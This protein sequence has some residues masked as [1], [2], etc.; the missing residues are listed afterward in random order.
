[1]NIEAPHDCADAAFEE[2]AGERQWMR[3]PR[4]S[5]FLLIGLLL[6]AGVRSDQYA[7]AAG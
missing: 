7:Q 5:K 3:C 1:M 6:G 4:P 2:L